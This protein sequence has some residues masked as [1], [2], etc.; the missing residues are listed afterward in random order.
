VLNSSSSASDCE[1]GIRFGCGTARVAAYMLLVPRSVTLDEDGDLLCILA[2]LGDLEE[3]L[4]S[5]RRCPRLRGWLG[6]LG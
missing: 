2:G 3:K 1:E 4:D 6:A 5:D